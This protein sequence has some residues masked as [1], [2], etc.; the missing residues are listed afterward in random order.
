MEELKGKKKMLGVLLAILFAVVFS[1]VFV[2]VFSFER[3]KDDEIEVNSYYPTVNTEFIE[4]LYSYIPDYDDYGRMTMYGYLYT[5]Y[6]NLSRDVVLGIIYNYIV[7]YDSSSL[8]KLTIQDLQSQNIGVDFS[9]N[10]TPLYKVSLSKFLEVGKIIFGSNEVIPESDFIID[11]ETRAHYVNGVGY[12]IY[13]INSSQSPDFI[14]KKVY[15]KY[16]ITNNNNT[17]IIYDYYV[18]CDKVGSACYDDE[19]RAKN[20]L[21]LKNVN[22]SIYLE[23]RLSDAQGYK[24]TFK[25]EDGNYYWYS[26]ELN[27]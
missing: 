9:E 17:I 27:D 8:E 20:N 19:K 16:E 21:V 7:K 3:K 4:Q 15:D 25:F 13:K 6:Q 18:K 26:S 22:G 2:K 23:N 14:V 1:A 11:Y 5:K 24:H 12:Q 10:L